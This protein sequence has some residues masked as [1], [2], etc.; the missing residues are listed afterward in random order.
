MQCYPRNRKVA[1][2]LG[3][4]RGTIQRLVEQE[5]IERQT[6]QRLSLEQREEAFRLLDE[7]VSL[8][9][10]ARQFGVNPESLRRLVILYQFEARGYL[11]G[12][13][14]PLLSPGGFY[15]QSRF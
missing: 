7:G 11:S 6:S 1:S 5:G 9:Q 13:D 3:T 2:A 15:A 10:V 14:Q 8:R 12:A 4:S